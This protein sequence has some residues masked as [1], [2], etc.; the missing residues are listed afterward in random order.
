MA[1]I[2]KTAAG[3][4]AVKQAYA[5]FLN[6]WPVA[7]EQLRVPTSQG[8]TFVVASGP[9]D[10]PAVVLL[11]GSASNSASWLGDVGRGAQD[12]RILAVDVIG[13]PGL[14]SASRPALASGAYL[15]WLDEVMAGLGVDRAALVGLSLGGWLALHFATQRPESVTAVALIAP[16]GVGRYKNVLLWAAPLLL[17]GGWGRRKVVDRIRQGAPPDPS[18]EA[19]AFGAFMD[20]IFRE[21]RPRTERLPPF[22]D[23]ALAR[24][25]MP[26]LAVLGGRDVFIDSAGTRARL[27]AGAPH[28]EVIYLPEAGHFLTGQTERVHGF[29]RAALAPPQ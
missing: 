22:T 21:F 17:L 7:S 10:A 3:E 14:S 26:V 18:P 28:A 1:G 5:R 29:L 2:W 8:E 13:E 23:A 19:Q 9:K 24:L 20:L 25:S 4:R 16:G 15:T 12:F 11:H 6:H 27:L